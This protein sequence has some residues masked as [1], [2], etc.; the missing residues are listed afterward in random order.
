[1]S[2]Q[3]SVLKMEI[4]SSKMSIDFRESLLIYVQEDRTVQIYFG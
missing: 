3:S 4:C 1:M 2:S